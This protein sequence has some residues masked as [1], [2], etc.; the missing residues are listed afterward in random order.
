MGG[1]FRATIATGG[2]RYPRCLC[3]DRMNRVKTRREKERVNPIRGDVVYRG[4]ERRLRT[5]ARARMRFGF[6]IMIALCGTD[7]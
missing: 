1:D 6:W 7:E 4:L 5:R 2:G 3:F